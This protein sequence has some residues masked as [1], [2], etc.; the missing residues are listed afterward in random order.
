MTTEQLSFLTESTP[1]LGKTLFNVGEAIFAND[2]L[3]QT[4]RCNMISSI[5][6]L[7]R[8]L[9]RRPQHLPAALNLLRPM[10]DE[11]SPG[12]FSVKPRRWETVRSDVMRA[13]ELTGFSAT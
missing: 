8:V 1:L 7:C 10:M 2:D 9:E 6:T 11:A 12:A 4:V 5:R 3:G 13:I